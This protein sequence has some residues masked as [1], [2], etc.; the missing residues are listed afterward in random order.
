MS[1]NIY[2]VITYDSIGL[3]VVVPTHQP[4]E[5]LSALRAVPNLSVI[6]P[7][8]ANETVQAWAAAMEYKAAPKGL[9][10]TRQNIPVLEG[11]KEKAAEGV[12]RG[13]YVLVEESAETPDVILIATGS[14]V[15]RSEERRVG[16]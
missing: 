3:C 4:V 13:G 1:T 2:C 15:Q 7:A 16:N 9:S 14:E 8:D 12:R 10:L 11:T 6:R 5:V